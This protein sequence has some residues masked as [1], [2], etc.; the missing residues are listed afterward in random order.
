MSITKQPISRLLHRQ[1]KKTIGLDN[2]DLDPK[3]LEFINLVNQSYIFNTEESMLYTTAEDIAARDYN[4]LMDKLKE[5]NDFLDTFN[6]GLAHDIKNHSSNIIGLVNML[7]KY[8][9]KE[10]WAM[11]NRIIEKLDGSSNQLTSI[12]KGFLVLSRSEAGTVEELR[13]IDTKNLISSIKNEIGFLI[14]SKEVNIDY[15]LSEVVFIESVVKIILVNLIS[16]S[17]KYS[18]DN[19]AANIYVELKSSEDYISLKV[20]DNGIGIDTTDD[21]NQIFNS[22]NES[23]NE[24]GYGVGLF[25]IKKIVKKN[26]ASITLKSELNIGTEIEITFPK[27]KQL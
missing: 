3:I 22:L 15:N 12:V 17:I 14:R 9:T 6:Q 24:K 10:N 19:E 18:K 26:N 5:K 11:V 8:A 13:K 21:N 16:N 7:K 2:L 20:K 25:L 23:T 27:K 1:L 4:E